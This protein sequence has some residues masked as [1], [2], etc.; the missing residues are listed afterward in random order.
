M[1]ATN[2]HGATI[3]A[4]AIRSSKP[5]ESVEDDVASARWYRQ[6]SSLKSELFKCLELIGWYELTS[7]AKRVNNHR[8]PRSLDG[9]AE[10]RSDLLSICDCLAELVQKYGTHPES[11]EPGLADIQLAHASRPP[12]GE[13]AH[14]TGNRNPSKTELANRI[15]ELEKEL[16]DRRWLDD[17]TGSRQRRT[18]LAIIVGMALAKYGFDPNKPGSPVARAISDATD[19]SI[20]VV[21][22]RTVR[23]FLKRGSLLLQGDDR[24]NE[25]WPDE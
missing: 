21:S 4:Q 16:E 3:C 2:V 19:K 14:S 18:F 25:D 20:T 9:A 5:N 23:D 1:T 15:H 22:E 7:A 12:S 17:T 24:G 11:W 13:T 10:L 8:Y 6:L